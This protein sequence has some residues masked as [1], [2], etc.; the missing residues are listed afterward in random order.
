MWWLKVAYESNE[1]RSLQ[2]VELI[3]TS[4]TLH[5]E[6]SYVVIFI[7][8]VCVIHKRKF[9]M[10]S[11]IR[12]LTLKPSTFSVKI[13]VGWPYV[14][15]FPEMSSFWTYKNAS[16]RDF[17]IAQNIRDSAVFLI[18][19]LT[20]AACSRNMFRSRTFAGHFKHSNIVYHFGASGSSCLNAVYLNIFEWAFALF[21][22]TF[23]FTITRTLCKGSTSYKIRY[24]SMSSGSVEQQILKHGLLSHL[25]LFSTCDQSNLTPA[26]L[27]GCR[28][29]KSMFFPKNLAYFKLL[30]WVDFPKW[31]KGLKYCINYIW[32]K[33]LH[34]KICILW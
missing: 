30:P 20:I 13:T 34:W 24:L 32:L 7:I 14:L 31:V 3:I 9:I 16:S 5:H 12:W 19:L 29:A 28:V 23:D 25:S 10:H 33:C 15:F 1:S 27:V 21:T 17:L 22:F 8:P 26:A 2:F 18:P 11:T 6:T 4:G